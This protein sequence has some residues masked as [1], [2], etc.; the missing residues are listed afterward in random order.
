[1]KEGTE[2]KKTGDKGERKAQ[3]RQQTE[4]NM[5]LYEKKQEMKTFFEA[6]CSN[7]KKGNGMIPER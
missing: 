1:M 3:N 4:K 7:G 5:N 2:R 6:F